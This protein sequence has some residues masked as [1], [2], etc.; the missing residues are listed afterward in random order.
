MQESGFEPYRCG[1][2]C[3][4]EGLATHAVTLHRDAAVDADQFTGEGLMIG[5]GV[6]RYR[7]RNLDLK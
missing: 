7:V 1:G 2:G 5:E 4:R 3:L 6:H